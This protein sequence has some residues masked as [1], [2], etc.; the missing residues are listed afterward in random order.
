MGKSVFTPWAATAM[1]IGWRVC[2]FVVV[3]L[4]GPASLVEVLWCVCIVDFRT[5][6]F[7]LYITYCG[8]RSMWLNYFQLTCPGP[9]SALRCGDSEAVSC[10]GGVSRAQPWLAERLCRAPAKGL[11]PSPAPAARQ[12]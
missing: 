2:L 6:A 3:M 8:V 9:F 11:Q 10:R 12:P 1:T 7:V 5:T 4:S